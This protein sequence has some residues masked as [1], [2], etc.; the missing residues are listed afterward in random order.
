MKKMNK[1]QHKK[2]IRSSQSFKQH[3]DIQKVNKTRGKITTTNL[4]SD[5]LNQSCKRHIDTTIRKI[6]SDFSTYL[7]RQLLLQLIMKL[8]HFFPSYP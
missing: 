1:E 7:C 3:F 4:L 6:I 5:G 2:Q 8:C